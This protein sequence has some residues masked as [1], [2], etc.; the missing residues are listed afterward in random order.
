MQIT[1]I[2]KIGNMSIPSTWVAALVAI[3]LTV[4]VLRVQFPKEIASLYSDLALTFIL[5]WKFSVILTDFALVVR[6]PLTILYFNGGKLGVALGAVAVVVQAWRKREK[7]SFEA[8]AWAIALTQAG[9]QISM[10]L[11]NDNTR[12]AELVT[13]AL[14]MIAL[15]WVLRT[16]SKASMKSFASIQLLVALVQPVDLLSQLSVWLTVLF[17]GALFFIQRSLHK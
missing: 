12:S 4:I 10:V 15:L 14:M 6:H 13:F 7:W 8:G 2:Y 11:T 5:V 17:V 1:D 9:F 16:A 3:L